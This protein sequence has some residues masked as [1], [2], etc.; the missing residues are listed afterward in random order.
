[1]STSTSWPGDNASATGASSSAGASMFSS[2]AS[3]SRRT[4]RS[5]GEKV[6]ASRLPCSA[7]TFSGAMSRPRA[8]CRCWRPLL[9]AALDRRAMIVPSSACRAFRWRARWAEFTSPVTTA[10]VGRALRC[11]AADLLHEWL[12]DGGMSA[13]RYR[14]E[15]HGGLLCCCWV[16]CRRARARGRG[17]RGVGAGGA[18]V[19]HLI[20]LAI[21]QEIRHAATAAR[22]G[23]RPVPDHRRRRTRRR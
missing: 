12:P 15:R 11:S 5:N 20:F 10:S 17:L 13:V 8:T 22:G 3:V 2:S 18:D 19:A 9:G 16:V 14:A 23:V 1:M 7:S 6:S 4:S 21:R